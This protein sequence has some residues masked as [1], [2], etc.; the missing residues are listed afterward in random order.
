MSGNLKSED[1]SQKLSSKRSDG[2]H[3]QDYSGACPEHADTRCFAQAV[4]G[5]YNQHNGA[6]DQQRT[7]DASELWDSREDM[8]LKRGKSKSPV[9]I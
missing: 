8:C 5:R 2:A 9:Y 6:S 3:E 7:Q 1:D 4:L